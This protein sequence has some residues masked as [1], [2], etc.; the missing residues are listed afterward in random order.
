MV[1]EKGEEGW[2]RKRCNLKREEEEVE[3]EGAR[4]MTSEVFN[5][6]WHYLRAQGE[7]EGG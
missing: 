6:P 2:E 5:E 3:E 1:E 7:G 4:E